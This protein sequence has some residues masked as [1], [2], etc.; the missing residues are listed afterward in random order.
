MA[1]CADN[2]K[3]GDSDSSVLRSSEEEMDDEG[4]LGRVPDSS[5]T[6]A[7]F[8]AY[9]F[10]PAILVTPLGALTIIIRHDINL[11]SN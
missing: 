11:A 9:A 3:P 8:A 6:I 5:W 1:H 2:G 10:A 4:F 7:N